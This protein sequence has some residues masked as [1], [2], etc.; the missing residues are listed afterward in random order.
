MRGT[1]SASFS[2]SAPSTWV[3]NWQAGTF[4]S[5][6]VRTTWRSGRERQMRA[7]QGKEVTT[8]TT[9]QECF[10][11]MGLIFL[12]FSLLLTHKRMGIVSLTCI[13]GVETI[14]PFWQFPV[15]NCLEWAA[16]HFNL[17]S[18]SRSFLRSA[19]DMA[20]SGPVPSRILVATERGLGLLFISQ[21]RF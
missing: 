1:L 19:G 8:V 13:L 18:S 11:E 12:L 15:R 9:R 7:A 4:S 14:I 2:C 17:I 5:V 10:L 21:Q 6:T 16:L 3:L 20:F